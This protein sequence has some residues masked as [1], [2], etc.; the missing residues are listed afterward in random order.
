MR[1]LSILLAALT[2]GLSPLAAQSCQSH[3][4]ALQAQLQSQTQAL[5]NRGLDDQA[6]TQAL[7]RI[8]EKIERKRLRINDAQGCSIDPISH[9]PDPEADPSLSD[10]LSTQCA[11]RLEAV[12][13]YRQSQLDKITQRGLTPAREEAAIA[14]LEA[15]VARKL[16]RIDQKFGCKASG[17]YEAGWYAKTT[18]QG[19]YEGRT[20][21]H[22]TAGIFGELRESVEGQD[23]NDVPA[24]GTPTF[25]I[26]FPKSDW[27]EASGDYFS[28]YRAYDGAHKSWH[29][30]VRNDGGIDL[31][32]ATFSL[33]IEGV[34]PVGYKATADGGNTYDV[35]ITQDTDRAA[36]LTLIDLDSQQAYTPA[37]LPT[38]DFSMEGSHARNFRWVQGEVDPQDYTLPALPA[39]S[40]LTQS[41]SLQVQSPGSTQ[42]AA[43][44]FGLP[45]SR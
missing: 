3:E 16:S 33:W 30:Q 27:G 28:D 12:E 22:T 31:S 32:A 18:L 26:L 45:P 2:L 38:Q 4:E 23:A 34:Y 13:A 43:S 7:M 29:F 11:T 36:T 35:S 10:P 1:T 9:T 17:N 44:K 25:Q 37:Q 40:T 5:G 14:R 41:R 39:P 19:E 21:S 42:G 6:Y 20:Y 15:N 8:E 24:I